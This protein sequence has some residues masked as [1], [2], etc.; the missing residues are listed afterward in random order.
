MCSLSFIS[1]EDAPKTKLF[2]DSGPLRLPVFGIT[3]TFFVGTKGQPLGKRFYEIQ[4]EDVKKYG[5]VFRNKLPSVEIVIL[6]DPADVAKFDR[7][8]TIQKDWTF[9][10]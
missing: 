9:R 8:P 1:V 6:S 5:K 4:A 2:S 7:I 10:L 3:W